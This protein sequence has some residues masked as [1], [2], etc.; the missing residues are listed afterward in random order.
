MNDEQNPQGRRPPPNLP[1]PGLVAIAKEIRMKRS[2]LLSLLLL[3][4]IPAR[5]E[6]VIRPVAAVGDLTLLTA[7]QRE[8][9]I[10][11]ESGALKNT[12]AGTD[13]AAA[14]SWLDETAA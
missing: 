9:L 11:F 12:V 1:R 2:L 10:A 13:P 6:E 7:A 14:A 8:W 3:S 5:A 4:Q